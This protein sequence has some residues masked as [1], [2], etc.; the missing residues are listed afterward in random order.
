MNFHS[1]EFFNNSVKARLVFSVA[2]SFDSSKLKIEVGRIYNWSVFC[3]FIHCSLAC[4][5][6]EAARKRGFKVFGLQNYGECWS[7]PDA[8]KTYN[9]ARRSNKCLMTLQ[10][11]LAPCD[12]SDP[13]ECVGKPHGNFMYE[14]GE[15]G[16]VVIFHSLCK[17]D[18]VVFIS[19]S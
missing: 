4:R 8:E 1:S 10:N 17:S 14:L 13:R 15:R 19:V 18:R 16:V 3:C 2:F 11:P 6:A 9:R 7:G 12:M 5:C